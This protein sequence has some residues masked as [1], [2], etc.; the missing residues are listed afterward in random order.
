MGPQ[1][2]QRLILSRRSISRI[3][4]SGSLAAACLAAYLPLSV[5][6]SL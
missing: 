1:K 5:S 6:L 3:S 2:S 4:S